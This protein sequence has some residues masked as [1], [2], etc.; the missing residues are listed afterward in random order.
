MEAYNHYILSSKPVDMLNRR[1]E[2]K[3]YLAAEAA[4]KRR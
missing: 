1:V 3:K 4:R 2:I